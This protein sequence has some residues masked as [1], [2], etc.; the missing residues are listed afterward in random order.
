MNKKEKEAVLEMAERI[1]RNH[2]DVQI[3]EIL[4]TLKQLYNWIKLERGR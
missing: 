2:K 3:S 4:K 1:I